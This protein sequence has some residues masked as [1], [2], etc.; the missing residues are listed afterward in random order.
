MTEMTS[1]GVKKP[2]I[3]KQ[4]HAALYKAGG[5]LLIIGGIFYV[6][7]TLAA[8][9]PGTNGWAEPPF[10]SAATFITAMANHAQPAYFTWTLFT[11]VD[12]IAVP[13]MIALYFALNKVNRDAVL[14][15]IGL[16]IMSVIL[17]AA[18]AEVG[19]FTATSLSFSWAAATDP[20][21]KA[22]YYV[23]ANHA[24]LQTEFAWT[25]SYFAGFAAWLIIS[26]VMRKSAFGKWIGGI[27]AVVSAL[28]VVDMALVVSAYTRGV[29]SLAG[30]LI[31]PLQLAFVV[32]FVAAGSRLF[33]LGKRESQNAKSLIA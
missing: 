32:F 19:F 1:T 28:F 12:F 24:V 16:A 30:S 6:L 26:L 3:A 21:L 5:I 18:V 20:M 7:V 17:D 9:T 2:Q 27:G 10:V 23:A 14:V 13:V 31:L 29:S 15:G 22:A 8:L 11:L 25:Y 33:T 4:G